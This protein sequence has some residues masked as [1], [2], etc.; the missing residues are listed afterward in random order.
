MTTLTITVSGNKAVEKIFFILNV[1]KSNFLNV[2]DMTWNT[3]EDV[4]KGEREGH[5]TIA[6]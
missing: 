3:V 4:L 5:Y 2:V 6:R 1:S